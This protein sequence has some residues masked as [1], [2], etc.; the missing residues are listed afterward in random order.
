MQPIMNALIFLIKLVYI[1]YMYVLIT[2]FFMQKMKA[3]YWNPVSQFVVKITDPVIK[4]LRRVIPGFKGYDLAIVVAMIVLQLF[5]V[6]LVALLASATWLPFLG[7]LIFSLVALLD[8]IVDFFFWVVIIAVISSWIP[9]AQNQP[10]MQ[11]AQLFAAPV[12][13]RV[14][15]LLPAMA[16][17][18]F[19]PVLVV[20]AIKL[21]DILAIYPLYQYALTML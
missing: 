6:Y 7:S 13:N 4:P 16:G 1:F 9:Q 5:Q 3:Q 2:R 18:D 8:H 19:S 14:R 11:I 10:V 21:I 15:G 17:I 12:L 20:V